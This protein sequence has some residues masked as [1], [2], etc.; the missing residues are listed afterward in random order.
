MQ[1]FGSLAE[2]AAHLAAT[3]DALG[4]AEAPGLEFA[5]APRRLRP[6]MGELKMKLPDPQSAG[7]FERG[8]ALG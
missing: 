4:F 6:G 8:T 7:P 5:S 2:P 3:P 1:K